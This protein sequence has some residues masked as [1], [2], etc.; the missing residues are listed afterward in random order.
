MLPPE[1]AGNG[2]DL[3]VLEVIGV[4]APWLLVVDVLLLFDRV[5]VRLIARG[6]CEVDGIVQLCKRLLVIGLDREMCVYPHPTSSLRLP[7]W[8]V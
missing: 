6:V 7:F 8:R 4:G 1:R 5:G 2:R 3:D